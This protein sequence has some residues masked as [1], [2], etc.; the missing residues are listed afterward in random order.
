MIFRSFGFIF[1]VLGLRFWFFFFLVGSREW[2]GVV[3]G[4]GGWVLGRELI[5]RLVG[6]LFGVLLEKIIGYVKF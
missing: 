6:E 2:D 5:F 4:E 3:R 1:N